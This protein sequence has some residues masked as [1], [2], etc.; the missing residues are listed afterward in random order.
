MWNGDDEKEKEE[1]E[2]EEGKKEIGTGDCGFDTI[3]DDGGVKINGKSEKQITVGIKS[4]GSKV[5]ISDSIKRGPSRVIAVGMIVDKADFTTSFTPLGKLVR[6]RMRAYWVCV[7]VIVFSVSLSMS[8]PRKFASFDM[9][10]MLKK[11]REMQ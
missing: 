4:I 10:I 5:P 9:V 3:D 11:R 6:V 2:E 8:I 7:R 1:E